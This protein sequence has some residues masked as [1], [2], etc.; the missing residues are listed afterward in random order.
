MSLVLT[1]HVQQVGAISWSSGVLARFFRGYM[2][3]GCI[4]SKKKYILVATFL[5]EVGITSNFK[6]I[7]WRQLCAL[8]MSRRRSHQRYHPVFL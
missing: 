3:Q 7:S 4:E 8:R 2:D 6:P 1:V 5:R